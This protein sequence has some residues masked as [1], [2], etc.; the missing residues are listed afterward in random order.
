MSFL[1]GLV[2]GGMS[3][4]AAEYY[5]STYATPKHNNNNIIKN[6]KVLKGDLTTLKDQSKDA[7]KTFS[8]IKNDV[9]NY[10]KDIQPDVAD[11]KE[12]V[13]ELKGNIEKLQNLGK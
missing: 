2:L 9:V 3:G 5:Q 1:F 7:A 6:I 11:L 12:S 4:V 13:S 10:T 8:S